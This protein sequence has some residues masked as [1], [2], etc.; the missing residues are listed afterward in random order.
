M[1]VTN[2]KPSKQVIF[3]SILLLSAL[4]CGALQAQDLQSDAISLEGELIPGSDQKGTIGYINESDARIV[5]NDNE[6]TLAPL[7][8]HNGSQWNRHRLLKSLQKGD[9]IEYE[10]SY[11]RGEETRTL[12]RIDTATK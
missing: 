11:E 5:I 10:L 1:G 7:V 6:F 9:F 8:R 12:I 4:S 2:V 3:I